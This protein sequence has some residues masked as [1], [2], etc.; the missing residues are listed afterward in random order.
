M[1]NSQSGT[2]GGTQYCNTTRKIGKYRNVFNTAF[3]SL[4]NRCRLL[5]LHPSSV[6]IYPYL[7]SLHVLV[8]LFSLLCLVLHSALTCM[9]QENPNERYH[10]T[11]K[12]LL[13]PNTISQKD[14][15]P[16]TTR[17]DDATKR[18]KLPKC[19]MKKS[20]IP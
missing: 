16:H 14:E 4:Y 3:T 13:L 19:C 7:Y 11:V 2:L 12:D 18:F 10:N 1:C 15:K 8:D 5:M 20:S 6:F 17:L 9:R